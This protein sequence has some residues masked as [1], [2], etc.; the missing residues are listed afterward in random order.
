MRW[1]AIF[2]VSLWPMTAAAKTPVQQF[3]DQI[4]GHWSGEGQIGSK[5][6]KFVLRIDQVLKN[7]FVRIIEE[8]TITEKRTALTY[9]RTDGLVLKIQDAG[10]VARGVARQEK[11][12]FCLT[13]VGARSTIR[14]IFR[15]SGKRL[16]IAVQ[17]AGADKNYRNISI[18]HYTRAGSLSP[19]PETLEKMARELQLKARELDL[20]AAKMRLQAQRLR[21]KQGPPSKP[22]D[23]LPPTQPDGRSPVKP[24]PAK[25]DKPSTAKPAQPSPPKPGKQLNWV[26]PTLLKT[27]GQGTWKSGKGT[28]RCI[29]PNKGYGLAQLGNPMWQDYI[30]EFEM[31]VKKGDLGLFLRGMGR[32]CQ[33]PN[34]LRSAKVTSK[35][36]PWIRVRAV[37]KGQDIQ[38]FIIWG[39][40]KKLFRSKNTAFRNG[41]FG[42]AIMA[43]SDI[44]IRGIRV[45]VTRMKAL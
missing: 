41:I 14:H 7:K 33:F 42:F 26:V 30:V 10:G 20:A 22:N 32:G 17:I 15:L 9:I 8:V 39:K 43:G 6:G 2:F 31:R 1:L 35:P 25:P 28:L 24:A 4:Q 38:V 19:T 23:P 21:I 44:E 16:G 40:Q 37:A 5:K 18:A 27:N 34:L 12:R 29:G 13:L 45:H 3:F 11:G 36:T